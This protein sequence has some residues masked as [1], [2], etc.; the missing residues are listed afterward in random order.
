MPC[1][2]SL[3]VYHFTRMRTG[4]SMDVGIPARIGQRCNF[5]EKV[6]DS[7][8]TLYLGAYSYPTSYSV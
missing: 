1:A 6:P 8:V 2:S 4:G 5:E 3:S 7:R